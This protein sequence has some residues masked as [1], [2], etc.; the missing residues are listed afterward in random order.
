LRDC[1]VGIF[2]I[3]FAAYPTNP[4]ALR[5][6]RYFMNS[7]EAFAHLAVSDRKYILGL[8]QLAYAINW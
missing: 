6:D 1:L 5:E 3:G 7:A 8:F 2:V 4:D